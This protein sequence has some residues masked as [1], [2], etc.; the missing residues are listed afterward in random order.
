MYSL[1]HNTLSQLVQITCSK[2]CLQK[3][4]KFIV[5]SMAICIYN[6]NCLYFP[7]W[8]FIF[9]TSPLSFRNIF[10]TMC[11]WRISLLLMSP[12]NIL[13][14]IYLENFF[15]LIYPRKIFLSKSLGN[16]FFS[17]FRELS[18][19]KYLQETSSSWCLHL[20][21]NTLA[22]NQNVS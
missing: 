17:M 3:N 22:H 6:N 12:R 19:S 4:L 15:F 1:Y 10:L 5:E 13:L 14:S 9:P 16:F 7:C 18:S 21:K 20:A 11:S 8:N 2:T